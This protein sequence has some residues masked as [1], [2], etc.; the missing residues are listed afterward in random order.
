METT[1]QAYVDD[2][3]RRLVEVW[4]NRLARVRTIIVANPGADEARI[5][6]RTINQAIGP[7]QHL[8]LR[9]PGDDCPAPKGRW[10]CL[11]FHNGGLALDHAQTELFHAWLELATRDRDGQL[12]LVTE[13]RLDSNQ[14]D[15]YWEMAEN[16]YVELARGQGT[17]HWELECRTAHQQGANVVVIRYANLFGPG[18]N[19]S[20]NAID[21]QPRLIAR[22]D[23]LTLGPADI[24]RFLSVT[25]VGD[26]LHGLSQ[27]PLTRPQEWSYNLVSHQTSRYETAV[28]LSIL[29]PGAPIDLPGQSAPRQPRYALLQPLLLRRYVKPATEPLQDQL[30]RTVVSSMPDDQAIAAEAE[31]YSRAS[32]GKLAQIQRLQ[33]EMLEDVRRICREHGLSYFL[34]GGS[35][36]G[37]IRHQGFIPWDDD[38]DL[39]FLREDFEVFRRV[40]PQELSA[41]HS[42]HSWR[43]DPHHHFAFDKV[44]LRGTRMSTELS[45]SFEMS[46]GVPID[47]FVLDQTSN[48]ALLR[49][50]HVFLITTLRRALTLK[51][52]DRPQRGLFYA[53]SV[54]GLLL[55]RLIPW[56]AAHGLLE[57]LLMV[58]RHSKQAEFLVDG[59]GFNMSKGVIPSQWFAQARQCDFEGLK[60]DVPAGHD[61]YTRLLYSQDYMTPVPPSQRGGHHLAG[62]DLGPY[63]KT[64]E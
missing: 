30:W 6:C 33:I 43:D 13:A 29:F 51:W 4:R 61:H 10:V 56:R 27:L 12:I 44:R 25:F 64:T 17:T 60:V 53:W 57:K 5:L 54:P 26:L 45:F 41:R 58:Y 34:G 46:D 9:H 32:H 21:D 24:N 48:N 28:A 36:L 39:I 49:R 35:L 14:R 23:R 20:W 59:V 42:Y 2:E 62:L 18:V 47:I 52:L 50:L 15:A 1:G 22:H 63:A 8:V 3:A 19:H 7:R 31:A 40:A 38:I 55:M 16:E 11:F 37:A